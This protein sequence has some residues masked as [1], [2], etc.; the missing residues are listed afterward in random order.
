[1]QLQRQMHLCLT[2]N[3]HDCLSFT[4]HPQS[5]QS[6]QGQGLTP[7]C[8]QGFLYLNSAEEVMSNKL[9]LLLPLYFSNY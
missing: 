4:K 3:L 7:L 5:A 2:F 6:A 9:L 1:M 8:S